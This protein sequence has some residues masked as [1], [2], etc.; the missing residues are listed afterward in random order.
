MLT[1]ILFK[2]T[3]CRDVLWSNELARPDLGSSGYSKPASAPPT[4]TPNQATLVSCLEFSRSLASLRLNSSAGTGRP[5]NQPC[6]ST[7]IFTSEK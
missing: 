2:G 5:K 3:T 6:I 4:Q 1:R 7:G